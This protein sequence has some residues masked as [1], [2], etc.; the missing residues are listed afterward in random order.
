MSGKA[1]VNLS[2]LQFGSPAMYHFLFVAMWLEAECDLD[3]CG[4]DEATGRTA[5]QR[6]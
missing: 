4:R 2:R 3:P 1:I 5:G 6:P